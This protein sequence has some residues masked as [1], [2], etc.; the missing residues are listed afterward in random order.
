[1]K[2]III[3]LAT[4]LGSSGYS[5]CISGDCTNGTGK[6]QLSEKSIY[7]GSFRK[8]R[9]DGKGKLIMADGSTYKGGFVNGKLQGTGKYIYRDDSQYIGR[10]VSGKYQG[11]GKYTSSNGDIYKGEWK[12][13]LKNGRGTMEYANGN[14]SSGI[15]RDNVQVINNNSSDTQSRNQTNQ[16][17]VTSTLKDC[18]REY[19]H[20]TEGRYTYSDQSVYEGHFVNG[21]PQGE[22]TLYYANGNVYVGGWKTHSPHGN[23]VISFTSGT[24]YAAIWE[25]GVPTQQLTKRKG[26][27][28]IR[29][30]KKYMAPKYD[31][32]VTVYALV[33]GVASY[34]HMPSLKYTDDDAYQMYAFL[35][36]PEGGAVPDKHISLLI[37]DAA[38][39][40]E[41]VKSL[42][43]V[44]QRADAND[45]IMMY[46][47]GHGLDGMYIPSDYD[48]YN[49]GLP[50]STI[51][52]TLSQS[53]AKHKICIADACHSGSMYAARSISPQQMNS[54]F[55][56]YENT[57][58]GVA[59]ITSSKSEEVSLE[60]SGLRQGVFSH[61]L[62]R[63]LKGYADSDGSNII[64]IA[65]LYNYVHTNVQSYTSK[66]QS[67][68]I[69]GNY[70]PNMP[71]GIVRY[72]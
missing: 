11:K 9:F 12:N 66:T 2:T 39:K 34:Q 16:I 47:S 24:V 61:F 19:C 46:F 30:T 40:N 5:Q 17:A 21:S 13:G 28:P 3:L 37:D 71:V 7:H 18:N 1:M 62:I 59:L 64:T 41:I 26:T 63:G 14:I 68:T 51:L 53:Q 52:Q 70:D 4:L 67:P 58:G 56:L 20:N 65:E 48:G 8:S 69:S 10:F 36:S 35:K 49:N 6:Y 42:E 57:T 44:C 32:T 33:V 25:Y 23:G 22:G 15:W 60:Y 54:Y 72:N 29:K 38:T 55:D 27:T 45:V 50:Y 31:P 43:S